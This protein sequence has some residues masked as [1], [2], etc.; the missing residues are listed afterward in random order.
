MIPDYTWSLM[1][2]HG[3]DCCLGAKKENLRSDS[4]NLLL[5]IFQ[6]QGIYDLVILDLPVGLGSKRPGSGNLGH[7]RL[8]PK[9]E[10]KPLEDFCRTMDENPLKAKRAAFVISRYEPS[11]PYVGNLAGIRSG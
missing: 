5:D 1:K 8:L 4:Q 3:L 6:C 9:P 10:P 7:N 11:S 2:D